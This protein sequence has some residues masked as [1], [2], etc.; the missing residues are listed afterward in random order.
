[1][2]TSTGMPAQHPACR[3]DDGERTRASLHFIERSPLT[4]KDDF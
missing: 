2:P 4:L 1:M 3:T